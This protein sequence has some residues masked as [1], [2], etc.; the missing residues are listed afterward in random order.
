MICLT[1][2]KVESAIDRAKSWMSGTGYRSGIVRYL[3]V[4]NPHKISIRHWV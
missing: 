4:C 3:D 1:K 2:S